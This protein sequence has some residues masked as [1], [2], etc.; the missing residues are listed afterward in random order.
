MGGRVMQRRRRNRVGKQG[1]AAA[2]G[3][4]VPGLE[5]ENTEDEE[6]E[7]EEASPQRDRDQARRESC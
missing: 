3:H 7:A 1:S 4:A 6:S 5:G 2:Q